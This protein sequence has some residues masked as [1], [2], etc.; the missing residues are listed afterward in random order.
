VVFSFF[1]IDANY[2]TY[3]A[4]AGDVKD[5]YKLRSALTHIG[6]GTISCLDLHIAHVLTQKIICTI[7]TTEQL[8]YLNP[9]RIC[10]PT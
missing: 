10:V 1:F 9:K 3:L 8:R 5:L 2:H 4:Y 6:K 7:I